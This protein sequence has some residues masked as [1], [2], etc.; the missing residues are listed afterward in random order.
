M[1]IGIDGNEANSINKVGVHQYAFEI[2]R[3]IY[4]ENNNAKSKNNYT[5]YLKRKASSDLPKENK[6]WRYK[7]LGGGR[8]WLITKLM[9]YLIFHRD[10]DVLFS[11]SHYLPPLTRTYKVCTIHDLGYLDSSGQF[12]KYDFW[13]LKYWTAIS[14]FVSSKLI[15]VSQSTKNDIVRHYPSA[16]NKVTVVHHGYDKRRFNANISDY[17]VRRIKRKYRIDSEYILFLS[18]IKPSKNIDGLIKA[19]EELIRDRSCNLKLVIAGK[20][21]W[22]YNKVLNLA[23]ELGIGDKVVFTGFVPEDDK[24]ILYYGAKLFALPAHWEGFGMTAL[25]AMACGTPVLVSKVGGLPEV[26]GKAGTYVDNKDVSDI[27]RGIK[28]IL[29]LSENKYKLLVKEGFVQASIF[30]WEK[31]AKETIKVFESVRETT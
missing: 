18:M 19:F 2:L 5:I 24:A 21:G 25:E 20:R 8:V 15:A 13:Q 17:N 23:N 16:T 28:K 11:P 12:K 22:H 31:A 29:D 6:Y 7:I 3:A 9:P 26:V 10:C 27:C 30:S 1:R 4:N 14:L